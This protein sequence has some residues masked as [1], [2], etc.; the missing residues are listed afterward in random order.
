MAMSR[1]QQKKDGSHKLSDENPVTR[2]LFSDGTL[3]DL[4]GG[5]RQ[6]TARGTR[7]IQLEISLFLADSTNHNKT[8]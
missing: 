2:D 1:E 5:V 7:N 8:L 3:L 6:N 4:P